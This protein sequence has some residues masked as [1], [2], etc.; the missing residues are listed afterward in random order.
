MLHEA[1]INVSTQSPSLQRNKKL[2]LK[3]KQPS[4]SKD[5]V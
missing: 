3:S 4:V 5:H 1:Q 2:A